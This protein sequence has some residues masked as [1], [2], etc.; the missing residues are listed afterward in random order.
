MRALRDTQL[1]A[2]KISR[3]TRGVNTTETRLLE[4]NKQNDPCLLAAHFLVLKVS[5]F[6]TFY[7]FLWRK[8]ARICMNFAEDQETSSFYTVF[9]GYSKR[10]SRFEIIFD[11]IDKITS[12][13]IHQRF[14]RFLFL[15]KKWTLVHHNYITEARTVK[16][17]VSAD[18]AWLG[19]KNH[20]LF[21]YF[22]LD[23]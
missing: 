20:F 12:F 7:A 2:H 8:C 4:T 13:C 1:R 3:C 22:F 17:K 5:I 15:V 21:F 16:M 6:W 11:L 18:R 10:G 14:S 19:Q 23:F 9:G